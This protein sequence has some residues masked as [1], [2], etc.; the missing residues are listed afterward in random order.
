MYH[1][2]II[3]D[4]REMILEGDTR[5]LGEFCEALHPAVVAEV[6]SELS[7]EDAWNVI[8]HCDLQRQVEL[9]NYL[10]LPAQVAIV[11]IID[12]KHLSRLLEEMPPDDRVDLLS[13]LEPERVEN[14]LPLIAQA[15]RN[16]IRRLLSY[17]EHSAGSIMTT[18]YASLPENVTAGEALNLLRKQAPDRET[19]Y[20]VYIVDSER[21]LDGFVSLRELI[22]AKPNTVLS[23]IMQRDVISVRV[24]DDQEF[25]AQ[26]LAKYDF[27]AIPVV[28]QG[29]HLVGIITHDDVLDVVQEEAT[30]DAHR[31]GGLEPLEDSYLETPLSTIAWKRG[32]WLLFL[33]VVALGTA[34]VLKRYE[35]VS[36]EFDWMVLF[37]PLVLASGGNTGSQSATLVIRTIALGELGRR[38][39]LVLARRELVIGCLL[40]SALA[41]VGFV[42]ALLYFQLGAHQSVVIGGTVFLVA[43][44]GT[45]CGAFLPL[46]FKRLGMDPAVMS[47]PL[48]AALV[49]VLGV[50]I[51]YNVT[52]L[53]LK[54]V[55]G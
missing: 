46:L 15:E 41:T 50:V 43:L 37:L 29:H 14:L 30:E 7:P 36:T 44:M 39:N 8:Q 5:G 4:L 12:R 49:D 13:R 52:L 45:V 54:G 21:R 26:E 16:D 3:P 31:L 24:D 38:E 1:S 55:S 20:Y 22:L 40:G 6:V 25:V 2:L 23:E 10:T 47:N 48:I 53:V 34:R 35:H 51:Y 27:I 32:V 9:F 18:E 42:A 19:I 17:D 28:D 11:D 33:A